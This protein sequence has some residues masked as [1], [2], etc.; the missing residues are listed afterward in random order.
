MQRKEKY[1]LVA[2]VLE[3]ASQ[4]AIQQLL[5][6]GEKVYTGIGGTAMKLQIESIPVF[7]KKLPLTN[8]EIQ[9]KLSTKNLFEL[10]TY[11]QY[12]VGSAGFSAWR[13][14][15]THHMTT[16]WVLN[17]ECANFPIMYGYKIIQEDNPQ[18]RTQ[19]DL[20][21]Y[22]KY[23]NGSKA[24]KNRMNALQNST[25]SVV[26][27]LE[28]IPYT[29]QSYKTHLDASIIERDLL[30]TAIFMESKGM[31]HF[32]GHDGNLLTDGAKLYFADFGLATSLNFDLSDAEVEF[33]HRHKRYDLAH[34]IFAISYSSPEEPEIPNDL[35]ILRKKYQPIS[36]IY[37]NF[38]MSLRHDETKNVIYPEKELVVL[39]EKISSDLSKNSTCRI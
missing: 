31:I 33:F 3:D 11:Y 10:P 18:K 27:F 8:I 2:K 1:Q 12:G 25:H 5:S 34:G 22:V 32:D 38:I 23:W 9:N 17:D 26:V 37:Q 24:I 29:F 13:E 16:E 30:K 4:E 14:L 39:T 19:D 7:A 20:P 28:F 6:S 15:Q 36:A 21:K 35:K